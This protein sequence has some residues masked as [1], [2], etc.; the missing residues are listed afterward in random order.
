MYLD[1]KDI[2]SPDLTDSIYTHGTLKVHHVRR[3]TPNLI[4]LYLNSTF[5]K[6]SDVFKSLTWDEKNG[7]E[8]DDDDDE[9]NL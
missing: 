1:T 5:N 8:E 9:K 7:E 4:D 3:L 6:S 2:E